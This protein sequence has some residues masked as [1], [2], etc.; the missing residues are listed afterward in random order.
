MTEPKI[1][2]TGSGRKFIKIT[3]DGPA[4]ES[5][6]GCA[7]NGLFPPTMLC[8]ELSRECGNDGIFK[9]IKS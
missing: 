2:E 6:V 7:A 9:E 5:C 3:V 1:Y 4:A 8:G